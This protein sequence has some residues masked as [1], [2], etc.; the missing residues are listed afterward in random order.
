VLGV[1][2]AGNIAALAEERGIP[3]IAEFFGAALAQRLARERKADLVIGNNVL[4]HVPDL[5]D[6]VE[7]IRIVLAPGGTVTMEFPHLLRLIEGMQYDTIYHEHFSY[8][9]LLTAERVFHEHGLTIVDVEEL[10]THGGSIR[11]W[12]RHASRSLEPAASVIALRETERSAGL[13][14]L[15]AYSQFAERVRTD[16]RSLLG[17]LIGYKTSGLR[18]AGYGAPAKGSTLLNYCGIGT[19]FIDFTVDIS[20]LKQGRFLPGAHIPI[21]A[22]GEVRRA[23]PDLLFVLPWNLEREITQ[24]M[25][26][27]RE[28]GGRFLV[29]RPEL[30]EIV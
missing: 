27:I 3:T 9:S 25:S 12:V 30:T 21:C 13:Y 24:S 16:K 11:V 4:A 7:G 8:F 10:P 1:E 26:Y 28:W 29:R 15:D 20:P 17:R 18:I 2:P 14:D 19:D 6:F 5:H 22:L 23:K